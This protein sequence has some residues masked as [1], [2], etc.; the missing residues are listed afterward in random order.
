MSESQLKI[1]MPITK[2]IS[3]VDNWWAELVGDPFVA[4]DALYPYL[5]F[6]I[7]LTNRHSQQRGIGNIS[8]ELYIGKEK[9]NRVE[10]LYV[11][12]VV[13][14]NI[15][16]QSKKS[17][18]PH[19][20]IPITIQPQGYI[21]IYSLVDLTPMVLN[22]IEELREGGDLLFAIRLK[23]WMGS[24]MILLLVSHAGRPFIRV[25]KSDWAENIL[26]RSGFMEVTVVEL[27]EP[28]DIPEFRNSLDYLKNAWKSYRI[29]EYYDAVTNVRRALDALVD[30]L[31]NIDP[32]LIVERHENERTI[33]EPNFSSLTGSPERES[34]VLTKTYRALRSLG[35]LS[36]HEGAFAVD[37]QLAEFA[38]MTGHALLRY[39]TFRLKH[40]T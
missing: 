16:S 27:P 31:R 36:A 24:K 23:L 30:G 33:R 25:A 12:P 8:G 19:R 32:N 29:G 38:V 7:R 1:E 3:P 17:Q 9:Q 5:A 14:A 11:S 37:K 40:R 6:N 34:E 4:T 22:R 13:I 28:I 26:K 39:V 2:S 10:L 18:E 21:E 35:G 15:V 20:E